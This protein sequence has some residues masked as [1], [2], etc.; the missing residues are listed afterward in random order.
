MSPEPL[1]PGGAAT[2]TLIVRDPSEN[3][4]AN[5][6]YNFEYPAAYWDNS[7]FLLHEDAKADNKIAIQVCG[8]AQ[9]E[10]RFEAFRL[11]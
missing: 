4:V 6:P 1:G 7:S 5:W 10:G 3:R 9:I 2:K 8:L 11:G